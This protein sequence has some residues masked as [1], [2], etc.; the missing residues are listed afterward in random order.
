M[1]QTIVLLGTAILKEVGAIIEESVNAKAERQQEII[2]RLIDTIAALRA[3]RV[4]SR[5]E[6]AQTDAE[7]EAKFRM[8]VEPRYGKAKVDQIL[9]RCWDLENLTSVTELM[10]LFD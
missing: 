9:A 5:A 7:V 3:Q 6:F 2:N 4:R 10:R 1:L 8:V